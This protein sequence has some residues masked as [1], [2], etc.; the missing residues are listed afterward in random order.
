MGDLTPADKKGIGNLDDPGLP[1]DYSERE[2]GTVPIDETRARFQWSSEVAYKNVHRIV[3]RGYDTTELVEEGYGMTD[4]LF[5]DFQ[6]RI[7]TVEEDQ[8]LNYV[9]IMALEDG[10]SAPAAMSRLVAQSKT[11]LTQA[12]GASIHAFGHAYGAYSAFGNRLLD[13][14]T[15][16]RAKGLD[17]DAIA[18]AIV[19]DNLDDDALGVSDLML[20]DPAAKRM[21]ERAR[22]LD[23]AGEYVE[24]MTAIVEKARA[25]SDTPVDIDMLGAMGSVMMDL[26][27]TPEATW[28]IL[29]VTRSFA[30]GAHF[31][32]EIER[33]DYRRLGQVLTPP[34]MY[35]GHPDRPVPPLAERD[36]LAK[37]ALSADLDEWAKSQ[38]ERRSVWGSGYSIHEEIEDPSKKTG[39]KSVGKKL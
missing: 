18:Q 19:N 36:A 38:E 1:F 12:C 15:S 26:G 24:L 16:G 8:M 25:A 20:K 37:L 22:K 7:P 11:F 2:Y 5:V 28:A 4:V 17:I 34:E 3:A 13:E 39:I 27:F 21:I 31:I 33:A 14:L 6:A 32:E 9:M 35:D 29:A 30:A 23:V 10:L